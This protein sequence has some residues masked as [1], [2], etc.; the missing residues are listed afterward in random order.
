ML[1]FSQSPLLVIWEVT[2]ACD[3]ACVHCRASAMPGRSSDELSTEEGYRL[4]DQVKAFGEAKGFGSPLFVFTGGDPLKRPDLYELIRYSVKLGLRTNVTPSSTPLLT[5]SAIDRF[6]ECG[7][8]RMA[9]SVDGADAVTHD[10]FRQVPGS[11]DRCVM[12]LKHAQKIGLD[13]QFQTTV[14]RRNMHQLDR[15]ADLVGEVGSKMWSLFFLIVTGRA[16]AG[17]DLDAAQYEEVF[18]KMYDI[19]QRVSFDIKTTEAMHYRRYIIERQKAERRA[20]EAP[21]ADHGA[22]ERVAFRTA[23]VSDGRGFVFVSHKGEVFPSGFLALSAGN[24]RRDSL[25]DVYRNSQLF[26][27][28]RDPH[29]REGKCGACE[30]VH[31]CGGSRSRAYALTGDYLAEDPRCVYQPKHY[32]PEPVHA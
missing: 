31:V 21:H 20:D 13:T 23:G 1:D 9:I 5:A 25:V 32:A 28:L 2:Q 30:Y 26:Q 22:A 27:M 15:I 10:A 29:L 16:L 11:F 19:S 18:A 8:T 6:K 24:V 7:V 4:L 14:T 3:L 17:D 12:A